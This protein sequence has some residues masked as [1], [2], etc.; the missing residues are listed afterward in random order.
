MQALCQLEVLGE[1]EPPETEAFLKEETADAAVR[2]YAK[3]LV[4]DAWQHR[5]AID[6]AIREVAEHW[7]LERMAV[8][9]R[10]TLRIAVC[11]L[12]HRPDVPP[13]VVINEAV[14]IGKTFGTRESGG[15]INGLLDAILKRA[16]SQPAAEPEGSQP[17]ES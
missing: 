7:K 1:D 12:K 4:N 8:V 5:E 6:G 15:F 11:E 3:E 9:D 14:E 13:R 17:A 10:N 2:R 16:D